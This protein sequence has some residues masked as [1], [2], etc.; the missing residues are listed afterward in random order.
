MLTIEIVVPLQP[1]YHTLLILPQAALHSML[2]TRIILK[3]RE[4]ASKAIVHMQM[5][6][7]MGDPGTRLEFANPPILTERQCDF[8][9]HNGRAF[10]QH[11]HIPE[12]TLDSSDT[13]LE[14]G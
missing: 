2:S 14:V 3:M 13:G 10:S 7:T 9:S 1:V 11:L 8:M 12:D 5:S 4:T 6:R